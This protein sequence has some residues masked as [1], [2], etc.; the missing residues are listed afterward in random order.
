MDRQRV[1]S[2]CLALL[3]VGASAHADEAQDLFDQ[4]FGPRVTQVTRTASKADDVALAKELMAAAQVCSLGQITE[5]L[6]EVGG[7]YR[8]NM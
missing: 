3:V 5:A 8:R 7:Q 4:L 2:C 6:F 1:L